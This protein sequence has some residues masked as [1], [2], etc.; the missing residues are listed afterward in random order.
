MRARR[1]LEVVSVG[2]ECLLDVDAP[3]VFGALEQQA[4]EVAEGVAGGV[5]RR[6]LQTLRAQAG[7][8]AELGHLERVRAAAVHPR[9][10]TQHSDQ[11]GVR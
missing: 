8:R 5:A 4:R 6:V 10:W 1:P 2:L 3:R 11:Q 9:V 7:H